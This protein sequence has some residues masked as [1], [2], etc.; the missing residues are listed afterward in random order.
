[1]NLEEALAWLKGARSTVNYAGGETPWEAQERACR[2]DAAAT[3]QAY[4]VVRAHKEGLV[5]S[6]TKEARQHVSTCEEGP[7]H[8][9]SCR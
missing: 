7:N 5:D 8:E 2:M 3:E 1:M 9:G 6:L 4:W